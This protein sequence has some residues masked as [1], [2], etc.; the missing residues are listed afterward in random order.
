MPK[1]SDKVSLSGFC[2]IIITAFVCMKQ[3]ELKTVQ[4][5][6]LYSLKQSILFRITQLGTPFN[7]II[8]H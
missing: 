4:F 7:F 3:W 1:T 5:M 2:R 6:K 8:T